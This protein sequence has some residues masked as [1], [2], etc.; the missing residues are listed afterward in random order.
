MAATPLLYKITTGSA[1]IQIDGFDGTNAADTVADVTLSIHSS[2]R[3][4]QV[5]AD[6]GTGNL[7]WLWINADL[8]TPDT[9]IWEF[10]PVA[11]PVIPPPTVADDH[12]LAFLSDLDASL[13]TQTLAYLHDTSPALSVNTLAYLS[14][15]GTPRT[16]SVADTA[17]G[18]DTVDYHPRTFP[19]TAADTAH[20]TDGITAVLTFNPASYNVVTALPW[21]VL[22]WANGPNMSGTADGAALATW[23][24]ETANALSAVQA[25]GANQ[26]ILHRN[27]S[28]W[29]NRWV[30]TFDGT[31]DTMLCP[32]FPSAVAQPDTLVVIGK[33]AVL[34]AASTTVTF[35]GANTG[36]TAQYIQATP[37]AWQYAAGNIATKGTSDTGKHLFMCLLNG[38]SSQLTVDSTTFSTSNGGTQ[39][40]ARARV[41]ANTAPANFLNGDI[42]LYGVL[43]RALTT[44]EQSDLRAW[45]QYYYVTP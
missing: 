45:S 24:D 10:I 39:T 4:I 6:D 44:K 17:H 26:P 33:L 32:S 11:P 31:N 3:A 29:N 16:A 37:T 28:G 7:D 22:L 23:A 25:T 34:P 19:V 1:T 36:S 40:L 2:Q 42:A 20:G 13:S 8:H 15:R 27:V 18:T 9:T 5:Y 30:V 14:D 35:C 21:S 12:N 41:G 43:S 38:T